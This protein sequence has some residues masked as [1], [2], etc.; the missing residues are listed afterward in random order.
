MTVLPGVDGVHHRFVEL[1]SLRMH[2]AE[3][4]SGEPVLLLH[5]FPQHWWEWRNVIPGLADR[6]HVLC[7]DLRGAGWT[8]APGNGYTRDQL[9]ADVVALLDFLGYER[10]HLLTHDWS[11]LIGYHLCLR[12]P[13]RVGRHLALS[14]P[15]PHLDFDIRF[16]GALLRRAWFNLLNPVPGLGPLLMRNG[17]VL[18]HMLRGFASSPDAFTDED[19]ELFVSRF[20]EPAR[21]RAGS[22]LYRRFIQPEAARIL[23]GAY[24]GTR[25]TTPTH[26][27]IGADDPNIRR[28]FLPD[29]TPYAD[30]LEL[31]FL[32]G[33][34][35]FI[36]DD[37]PA[38]VITRATTFFAA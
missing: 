19:L 31:E 26:V 13:E 5:G 30:D 11:S 12:Y 14:I 1:P 18:R 32:P 9:L 24:R 10:V 20:R 3:A 2:L 21:A 17:K 23:T 6:Y 4:G 27:I 35:H 37:N 22:A 8:D 36:A 7:P 28:E 15:P 34:S 16:V 33:A 25:L 29:F 38:T